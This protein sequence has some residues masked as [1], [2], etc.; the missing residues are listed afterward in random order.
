MYEFSQIYI[1][2]KKEILGT[3]SKA[4]LN[5]EELKFN[6]DNKPRI[7]ANSIN[8]KKEQSNF[9]KSVFTLCDYR[10]NDKCPPWTIQ[11]KNMLHDN[12]KKTIYYKNALIK[13]YNIPIFYFPRLSHP[14]PTV[15]RRSGFCLQLYMILKI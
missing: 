12:I 1:D 5:Q 10:T 13:V 2:T 9:E 6:R 7:F 11:S 14:D 8:I 4:F 15:K 3:D